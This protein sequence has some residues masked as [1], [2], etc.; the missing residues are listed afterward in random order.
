[1]KEVSAAQDFCRGMGVFSSAQKS[2][3]LNKAA[4]TRPN[5]FIDALDADWEAGDRPQGVVYR[6]EQMAWSEFSFD[7]MLQPS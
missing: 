4:C 7:S 3:A 6:V 5:A 2:L 1:M